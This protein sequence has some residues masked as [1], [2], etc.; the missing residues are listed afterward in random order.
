MSRNICVITVIFVI[1]NPKN[2]CNIPEYDKTCHVGF[3]VVRNLG[4]KSLE[5]KVNVSRHDKTLS[6]E[7]TRHFA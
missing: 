3:Y 4:R 7:H 5:H 6:V 1:S 2:I